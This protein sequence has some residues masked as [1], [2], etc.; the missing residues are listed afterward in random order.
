M[1]SLFRLCT[2]LVGTAGR[3]RRAVCTAPRQASR[4]AAATGG[5]FTTRSL[6]P[7]LMLRRVQHPLQG[8]PRPTPCPDDIHPAQARAD[9]PRERGTW[10]GAGQS[11][12]LALVVGLDA[13][14]PGGGVSGDEAASVRPFAFSVRRRTTATHESPRRRKD[15]PMIAAPLHLPARDPHSDPEVLAAAIRHLPRPRTRNSRPAPGT[16][17]PSTSA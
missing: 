17:A 9:H 6:F 4:G 14:E 12:H 15:F 7:L 13:P 1:S 10:L 5:T 16:S 11:D 3:P 8:A 2:S